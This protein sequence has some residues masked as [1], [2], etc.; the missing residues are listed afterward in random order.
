MDWQRNSDAADEGLER[1][2]MDALAWDRLWQCSALSA[3]EDGR[4]SEKFDHGADFGEVA[5]GVDTLG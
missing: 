4:A 3:E 5:P 1:A 2:T